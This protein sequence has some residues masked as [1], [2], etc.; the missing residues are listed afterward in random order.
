MAIYGINFLIIFLIFYQ[1]NLSTGSASHLE[2]SLQSKNDKSTTLKGSADKNAE[3]ENDEDSEDDTV[4]DYKS[5]ILISLERVKLAL[6][7][8][9]S[10]IKFQYGFLILKLM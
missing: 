9:Q 5:K 7:I 3:L 4:A 1:L 2:R 6:I 10:L 8:S